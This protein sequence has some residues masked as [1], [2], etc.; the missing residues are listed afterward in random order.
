MSTQRT[1]LIYQHVLS[2]TKIN[3]IAFMRSLT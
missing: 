3:Y 2:H 1:Y